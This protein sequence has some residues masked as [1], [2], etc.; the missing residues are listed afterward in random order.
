MVN[1]SGL[2]LIVPSPY[3]FE[4]EEKILRRDGV[5]VKNA[6]RDDL[7]LQEQIDQVIQAIEKAKEGGGEQ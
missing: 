2:R 1:E 4:P 3:V 6:W 7:P 5:I